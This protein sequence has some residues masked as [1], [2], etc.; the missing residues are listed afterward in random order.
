MVSSPVSATCKQLLIQTVG[1]SCMSFRLLPR[2]RETLKVCLSQQHVMP[3]SHTSE[4]VCFHY[5]HTGQAISITLWS[6]FLFLVSFFICCIL[7]K[8]RGVGCVFFFKQTKNQNPTTSKPKKPLTK[9]HDHP[10]TLAIFDS[11]RI[12]C[13]LCK[14]FFS[15]CYL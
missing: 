7:D 14:F 6:L 15:Y 2:Y 10:E 1:C 5:S 13:T 4:N 8:V 12:V 9:T 3:A 11:F